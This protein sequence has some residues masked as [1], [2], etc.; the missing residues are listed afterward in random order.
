MAKNIIT[1]AQAADII[2][3]QADNEI[4]AGNFQ[5]FQDFMY[6]YRQHYLPLLRAIRNGD[7][8]TDKQRH[9]LN[10]MADDLIKLFWTDEDGED[11]DE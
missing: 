2:N 4:K 5:T 9:L 6:Y 10:F 8:L 11:S 7:E 1:L 3:E